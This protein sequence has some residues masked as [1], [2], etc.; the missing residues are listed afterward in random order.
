MDPARR[1]FGAPG[2]YRIVLIVDDDFAIADLLEMPLTDEG[3]HASRRRMEARVLER[4]T[5]NSPDFVAD[6]VVPVLDE[7][8]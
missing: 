6:F 7:P 3:Y 2:R 8:D 1:R 5:E 4:L